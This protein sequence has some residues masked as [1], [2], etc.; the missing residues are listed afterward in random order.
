MSDIEH[1][2]DVL[3]NNIMVINNKIDELYSLLKL[4]NNNSSLIM[5]NTITNN[6]KTQNYNDN[7]NDDNNE[8]DNNKN[9]NE[10]DNENNNNNDND[11]DDNNENDNN[12]NDNNEND[13]NENDNE[14]DNKNDNESD[15]D[16]SDDSDDD[17]STDNG[18]MPQELDN[19]EYPLLGSNNVTKNK[20]KYTIYTPSKPLSPRQER[21]KTTILTN[22]NREI[23]S[24]YIKTNVIPKYLTNIKECKFGN[25]CWNIICVCVHN[26]LQDEYYKQ[27]FQNDPCPCLTTNC[28]DIKFCKLGNRCINKNNC[29]FAHND[30]QLTEMKTELNNWN[31]R[32]YNHWLNSIKNDI[33]QRYINESIKDYNITLTYKD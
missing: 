31:E 10:N 4:K 30:K 25:E 13:N 17:Y 26:R 8:N 12:E 18:E 27:F 9:N 24:K 14:N 11:N 21:N 22:N 20:K 29:K 15:S 6:I 23:I 3:N 33:G 7:N 32:R 28:D 1:K 5:D 16:D 19:D 2:I